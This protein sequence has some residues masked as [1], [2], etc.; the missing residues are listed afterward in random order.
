MALS[1]GVSVGSKIAV[2][3]SQVTVKAVVNPTLMVVRVNDGPDVVVSDKESVE[4]MP[5]VKVFAGV[6]RK[7][8]GGN[9]LAFEAPRDISIYRLEEVA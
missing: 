7:A 3:Q 6:G 5:G 9:R 4:I 2:G 8:S 1:L